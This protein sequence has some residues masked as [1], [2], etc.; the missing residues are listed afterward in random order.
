MS[1]LIGTTS[2]QTHHTSVKAGTVTTM[3]ALSQTATDETTTGPG[4]AYPS[5]SIVIKEETESTYGHESKTTL[6]A[7][8]VKSLSST[9][10]QTSALDI[11]TTLYPTVPSQTNTDRTNEI[12]ST[13]TS[14]PTLNSNGKPV[15]DTTKST[16]LQEVKTTSSAMTTSSGKLFHRRTRVSYVTKT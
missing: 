4:T 14:S 9:D 3:E 10:S 11:K 12:R 1:P 5:L 13:K 6:L 15:T 16:T 2:E 8:L 7:S